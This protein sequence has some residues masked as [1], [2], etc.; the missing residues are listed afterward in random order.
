[1]RLYSGPISLFSAKVR[2]VLAEKG[3]DYER[4][5]V[6]Y[7]FKDAYLPHHPDVDRLNPHGKVPVLVDGD[8]VVY[9]S[10]LIN[11]YLEERHPE[12]ALFPRDLAARARCR[13]LEAYGDEVLF[14]HVWTLIEEIIYATPESP[15]NPERVDLA[16]ADLEG[17]Y[18]H[19]DRELTG[20]EH[21]C[22]TFSVADITLFV[23][24]SAAT[25]LS[26]PIGETHANLRSWQAR[27]AARPA[28]AADSAAMNEFVAKEQ[29]AASASDSGDAR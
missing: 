20:L 9:D 27:V 5:E 17:C 16:R 1:M 29:M 6:G 14:P 8:L 7:S 10:T 15:P 19:L 26:G 13:Q 18:A 25:L 4:I 21:F 22:S 12:P 3:I 23:F 11:E 24:L 2:V 28:V